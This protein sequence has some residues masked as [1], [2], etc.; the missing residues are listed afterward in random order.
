MFAG[1]AGWGAA[2]VAVGV[3]L[4]VV[5]GVLYRRAGSDDAGRGS[6]GQPL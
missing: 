4:A 3:L 5:G 1:Y 2:Q 6:G